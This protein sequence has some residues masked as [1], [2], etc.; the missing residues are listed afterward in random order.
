MKTTIKIEKEIEITHVSISIP[1]NYGVEDIPLDFPLRNG[2]TWEALINID[3]GII[4]NWPDEKC[5]EMYMKVTDGGTYE[6][7]DIDGKS[8]AL[9]SENYVPNG[10]I[11]GEYGD[12]VVLKINSDGRIINWASNIDFSDFFGSED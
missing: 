8:V 12:Y 2:D 4:D 11:P 3:T 5:A 9:I 1:I 10:V 7:F 6:L